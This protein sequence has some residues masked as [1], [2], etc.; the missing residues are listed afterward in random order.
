GRAGLRRRAPRCRPRDLLSCSR[1]ARPGDAPRSLGSPTMNAPLPR[2]AALALAATLGACASASVTH[3]KSPEADAAFARIVALQGDWANADAPDGAGG[4][5]AANYRVT[6]G[7]SAVIETLFPGQPQE[8]V[9]VYYEDGGKVALTHYCMLANQPHMRAAGLQ[10][11]VL[12]FEYTGGDGIDVAHD[13][14]MHSVA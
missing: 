9:T 6:S 13:M 1:A 10:G 4:P 7:G 11:N 2:L 14:H 8:M 12:A 3:A 5:V